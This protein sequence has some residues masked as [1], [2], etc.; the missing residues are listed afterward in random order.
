MGSRWGVPKNHD[1]RNAARRALHRAGEDAELHQPRLRRPLLAADQGPQAHRHPLPLQHHHHVH[2][3]RL[4]RHDDAHRAAHARGGRPHQRHVQQ[5]LHPARRGDDL[6]LP[7][8][9]HPGGA[10]QF[11]PADHARREGPRL[12]AAE[13]SELVRL[14]RRGGDRAL[15]D[16][17]RRR[18][19]RL[20]VL[21]AVLDAVLEHARLRDDVRRLPGR[22]LVDSHRSEFHGHDPP[23]ARAG[24][25]V[26]PPAALRLVDLRDEHRAAVGH[27]GAGDHAGHDHVRA[28]PRRRL[29]RPRPRR[30]SGAL[31]AHVLVLL[32][33]GRL[34]HDPAGHG[35]GLGG[36]G[37]VHAQED[38][39]LQV[40]GVLVAGLGFLVWAH[41]PFVAGISVYSAL[42][43]AFLSYF[44]AIPSAIKVFN[45]T[46]TL[47]KGSVSWQTP[48]L[49]I[50]GFIGLFTIGGVTGL[51]L[52]ALGLDIHVTDT[53]FVVAHFHYVMVG[54]VVMAYLA[55]I[56]YW[57]PKITGRMYPEWWARLAALLVF[58]GFNL[59]FLP[60]FLLGY[61]G[62]PRRYHAY[63]PEFQVLNVMSSAGASVLAVGYALPLVYLIWSLKGS[64]KAGP[65]PWGAVGLEWATSSPPPKENF[66]ETPVVTWDAYDYPAMLRAMGETQNV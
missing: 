16:H 66:H 12:S 23:D 31:P 65:N 22:L 15:R 53:Y 25:D 17:H 54:G 38:L 19:H 40:R 24:A 45:W 28:R 8:P 48:M 44:V 5:I 18:R 30:R 37:G 6:L 43:F 14:H 64:R 42:I 2:A 20:D 62:M 52:A 1:H 36:R 7:H 4:L 32:A 58:V 21:H 13:P 34:H 10:R 56:H 47:Y 59:T 57:W 63:A 50:M 9:R 3:R 41:H 49:Y 61:L 60:Q 27:A 51:F 26:V 29:L 33:P 39:R 46:A 11:H 35:R 55:G